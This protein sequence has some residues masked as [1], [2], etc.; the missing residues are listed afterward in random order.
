MSSSSANPINDDEPLDPRIQIELERANAAT[1]EINNL[2]TQLSNAQKFFQSTFQHSKQE[3]SLLATNQKRHIERA[4]PFYQACQRANQAQLDTQQAAQEYQ[5]SVEVF[6]TAEENLRLA[7]NHVA[8]SNETSWEEYIACAQIK[9]KQAEQEKK[10]CE[11][12]HEEKSKFYQDF[13]RQRLTLSQTL[14]RSIIK[15]KTY[16]E[17][18]RRAED[19]LNKQKLRIDD[20]QKA[21]R[22]AKT[23]YRTALNNL[24]QISEEIHLKR[25]KPLD[26]PLPPREPTIG[27]EQSTPFIEISSL[28]FNEDPSTVDL[29]DGSTDTDLSTPIHS[30]SIQDLQRLSKSDAQIPLLSQLHSFPSDSSLY[31]QKKC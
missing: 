4:R 23:T 8:K 13:E 6:H 27:A 17:L 31:V 10:R 21:I 19:D 30:L 2:E 25:Q 24:E 12:I 7:Q 1:S 26:L 29:S 9:I 16:F 18:K 14:R 20:V 22:Q 28:E 3:L 5:Y 11:Q 15:S